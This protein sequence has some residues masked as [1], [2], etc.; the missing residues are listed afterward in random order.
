MNGRNRRKTRYAHSRKN[1][2]RGWDAITPSI[3]QPG[4][5]FHTAANAAA[6]VD[7]TKAGITTG[8]GAWR[9][10][11]SLPSVSVLAKGSAGAVFVANMGRAATKTLAISAGKAVSF[12]LSGLVKGSSLSPMI[13]GPSGVASYL[14]TA[15][16]GTNGTAKLLVLKFSQKGTYRLLVRLS[17]S[18]SARLFTLRV[19]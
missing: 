9:K 5:R 11:V 7:T 18:S 8:T 15:I 10:L 6:P 1:S 3:F 16:A 12:T 17:T 2:A 13:I 4:R 19:V 14:T